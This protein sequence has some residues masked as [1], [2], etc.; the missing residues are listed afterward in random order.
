[1]G[2][3]GHIRRLKIFCP[4]SAPKSCLLGFCQTRPWNFP[5]GIAQHHNSLCHVCR[6]LMPCLPGDRL[7][8]SRP[9][10]TV[11]FGKTRRIKKAPDAIHQHQ[12]LKG[13]EEFFFLLRQYRSRG[14]WS[15]PLMLDTCGESTC[16]HQP[17]K[18]ALSLY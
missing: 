9:V 5:G 14:R 8:E 15:H 4:N 2:L 7:F 18:P 13:K 11:A 1:M 17:Q 12:G 3:S 10:K 16:C 6:R